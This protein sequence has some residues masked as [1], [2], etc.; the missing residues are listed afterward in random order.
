ME[1]DSDDT[2]GLYR[3]FQPPKL[4]ENALTFYFFF[5]D[6]S[7]LVPTQALLQKIAVKPVRFHRRPTFRCK[8]P[9]II[10]DSGGRLP[11]RVSVWGDCG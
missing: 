4:S 7:T 11:C 9:L 10:P 3:C 1:A 6:G 8:E 2:A 5:A